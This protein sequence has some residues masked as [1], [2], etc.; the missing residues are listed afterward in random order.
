MKYYLTDEDFKIAA[1][2]G[3]R[4]VLVYQRFYM[5]GWSAER[6]ITEPVNDGSKI[7]ELMKIANENGIEI[8][9]NTLA[10]RLRNGWT[11]QESTTIP[12]GGPRYDDLRVE[13]EF[14]KKAKANGIARS[15]YYARCKRGW[16]REDASVKPIDK[17]YVG[18]WR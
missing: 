13:R 1:K 16:S 9:R 5:R 10:N 11:E 6:A 17:R 4:E 15:T 7:E 2:N 18:N 8:H 12:V 14:L 3:L